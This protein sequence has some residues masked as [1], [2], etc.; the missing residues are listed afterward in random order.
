MWDGGTSRWSK[1]LCKTA[2]DYW[3][4]STFIGAQN[5]LVAKFQCQEQSL[6][7]RHSECTSCCWCWVGQIL[8]WY[9]FGYVTNFFAVY[10][11][12]PPL[13]SDLARVII[14]H[15]CTW[16]NVIQK[17]FRS[18]TEIWKKNQ[19]VF[20]KQYTPAATKSKSY[21]HTCQVSLFLTSSPS[22]T[23][24]SLLE[25]GISLFLSL[26]FYLSFSP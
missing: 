12:F 16:Y 22:W 14:C 18:Y 21:F 6:T 10:P 3:R 15:P 7:Y 5:S 25:V 8:D 17:Q 9:K 20:V 4:P 2:P 13:D 1:R 23:F 11:E 26:I 24:I 19:G